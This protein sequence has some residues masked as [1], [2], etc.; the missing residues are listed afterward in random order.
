MGLLNPKYGIGTLNQG[1]DDVK[2][3]VSSSHVNTEAELIALVELFSHGG[4]F[5]EEMISMSRDESAPVAVTE[6]TADEKKNAKGLVELELVF[7]N[8]KK[9]KIK[10]NNYFNDNALIGLMITEIMNKSAGAFGTASKV[11]AVN[12][13]FSIPKKSK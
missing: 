9:E 10:L 5:G 6:F 7:E 8:G 4:E 2:C 1:N 13:K 12:V 11:V 3:Q